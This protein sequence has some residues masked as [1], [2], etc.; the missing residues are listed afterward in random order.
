M[1]YCMGVKILNGKTRGTLIKQFRAPL[2]PSKVSN[3]RS[4]LKEF[5]PLFKI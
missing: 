2:S 1:K 4:R 5:V 3:I